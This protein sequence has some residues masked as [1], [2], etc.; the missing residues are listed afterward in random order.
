MTKMALTMIAAPRPLSSQ[1]GIKPGRKDVWELDGEK[2]KKEV[3]A[4][5]ER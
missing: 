3:K 4:L 2:K 1:G 5:K